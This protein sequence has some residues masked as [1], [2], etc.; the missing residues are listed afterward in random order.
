MPCGRNRAICLPRRVWPSMRWP[1]KYPP[2]W[3]TARLFRL[4]FQA[5]RRRKPAVLAIDG[6][7]Y[8]VCLAATA[9]RAQR[10]HLVKA[11]TQSGFDRRAAGGSFARLR[12]R[13]IGQALERA[14]E[15]GGS[16]DLVSQ[17]RF[18]ILVDIEHA[19][20]VHRANTPHVVGQLIGIPIARDIDQPCRSLKLEPQLRRRQ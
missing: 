8:F 5:S 9:A 7:Q 1:Q 10:L 16:H 13:G 6:G 4:E 3:V 17:A 18:L 2:W 14:R 15:R 11:A 19:P 12:A 20:L